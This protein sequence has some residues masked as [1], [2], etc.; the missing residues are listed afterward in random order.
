[1]WLL[2]PLDSQDILLDMSLPEISPP[3]LFSSNS[4]E[5]GPSQSLVLSVLGLNSH[6]SFFKWTDQ[7]NKVCMSY[8]IMYFFFLNRVSIFAKCQSKKLL[9][10]PW[11]QCWFLHS[12]FITFFL[13]ALRTSPCCAGILEEGEISSL[14]S[15]GGLSNPCHRKWGRVPIS[16]RNTSFRGKRKIIV[17]HSSPWLFAAVIL[18]KGEAS[19]TT[20]SREKR[21]QCQCQPL[22]NVIKGDEKRAVDILMSPEYSAWR[23]YGD[24][25]KPGR[26][27]HSCPF[28]RVW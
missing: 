8:E 19:L 16:W 22:G 26:Q 13:E 25:R 28:F 27:W 7:A 12:S 3:Q 23:F 4:C 14:L 24:H 9:H 17:L 10:L 5:Q 1:M 21:C 20:L 18:G 15:A 2:H 11:R 6:Y